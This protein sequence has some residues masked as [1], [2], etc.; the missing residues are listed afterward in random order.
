MPCDSGGQTQY[1][2]NPI[3]KKMKSMLC[4]ACRALERLG[5][6][7][8]ENPRL[9]EWWDD[10]KKE[11]AKREKEKKKKSLRSEVARELSN[12]P[13]AELSKEDKALL[14]EEGYL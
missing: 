2:E 10:H 7:F 11:D 1:V 13:V 14:R 3:N 9:S 4:S 5:Y 12:K 8:D 6:D